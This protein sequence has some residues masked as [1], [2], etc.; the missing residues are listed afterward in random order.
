MVIPNT[1]VY[2]YPQMYGSGDTKSKTKV[3]LVMTS[4]FVDLKPRT[5]QKYADYKQQYTGC[6][7]MT[8]HGCC[9]LLL[10]ITVT[11]KF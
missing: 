6:K 8:H 7:R 5:I 1:K 9:S 3:S 10:L 2:A 11:R 4:C